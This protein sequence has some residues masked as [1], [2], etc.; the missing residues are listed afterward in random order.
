LQTHIHLQKTTAVQVAVVIMVHQQQTS[1]SFSFTGNNANYG[2]DSISSLQ[3]GNQDDNMSI[4]YLTHV[5]TNVNSRRTKIPPSPK[6]FDHDHSYKMPPPTATKISRLPPSQ[7]TTMGFHQVS[8][9]EGAWKGVMTF[10]R[11]VSHDQS[12]DMDTT[13]SGNH[14]PSSSCST[15]HNDNC[16]FTDHLSSSMTTC[17][18]DEK[19]LPTGS[20]MEQQQHLQRYATV[21]MNDLSALTIRSSSTMDS[22]VVLMNH[23]FSNMGRYTVAHPIQ[24]HGGDEIEE[25][26]DDGTAYYSVAALAA[27]EQRQQY[28]P[29]H[30]SFDLG[31]NKPPQ[32]LFTIDTSTAISSSQSPMRRPRDSHINGNTN[33]VGDI[34]ETTSL[35]PERQ[36]QHCTQDS[37]STINTT[38][39]SK[40]SNNNIIPKHDESYRNLITIAEGLATTRRTAFSLKQPPV[41]QSSLV[42]SSSLF[43]RER[44]NTQSLQSSSPSLQQSSTIQLDSST[45]QETITSTSHLSSQHHFHNKYQENPVYSN[46]SQTANN[47]HQHVF[48]LRGNHFATST[49]AIALPQEPSSLLPGEDGQSASTQSKDETQS[50]GEGG[51][52]MW[53]RQTTSQSSLPPEHASSLVLQGIKTTNSSSDSKGSA[54]LQRSHSYG[55]LSSVQQKFSS[56]RVNSILD[57]KEDVNESSSSTDKDGQADTTSATKSCTKIETRSQPS[58]EPLAS[59]NP[60]A[61]TNKDNYTPLVRKSLLPHA[62]KKTNSQDS[63]PLYQLQRHSTTTTQ[64]RESGQQDAI[65]SPRQENTATGTSGYSMPLP[66]PEASHCSADHIG[67]LNPSLGHF[68]SSSCESLS[69]GDA[70]SKPEPR[71]EEDNTFLSRID[72]LKRTKMSSSEADSPLV[73]AEGGSKNARLK[74][75]GVENSIISVPSLQSPEQPSETEKPKEA[76]L[77][78]PKSDLHLDPKDFDSPNT[79][80]GKNSMHISLEE[81]TVYVARIGELEAK[82][83]MAED[84]IEEQKSWYEQQMAKQHEFTIPFQPYSPF[85]SEKHKKHSPSTQKVRLLERNQTLLKE[86]RFADQTCV[87][88]SQQNA[89][90]KGKLQLREKKLEEM[91]QEQQELTQKYLDSKRMSATAEILSKELEKANKDKRALVERQLHAAYAKLDCQAKRLKVLRDEHAIELKAAFRSGA[92]QNT[93]KID[94]LRFA[95]DLNKQHKQALEGKERDDLSLQVDESSAYKT[96]CRTVFSD[97]DKLNDKVTQLAALATA[98]LDLGSTHQDLERSRLELLAARKER[99]SYSWMTEENKQVLPQLKNKNDLIV[100]KYGHLKEQAAQWRSKAHALQSAGKF[101]PPQQHHSNNVGGDMVQV[102]ETEEKFRQTEFDC[103][104]KVES[105]TIE[106]NMA[107]FSRTEN[108]KSVECQGTPDAAELET[109]KINPSFLSHLLSTKFAN[110]GGLLSPKVI[111]VLQ[112]IHMFT[113]QHWDF[114]DHKIANLTSLY[115]ERLVKLQKLVTHIR[116]SLVFESEFDEESL[117][118]SKVDTDENNRMLDATFAAVTSIPDQKLNLMEEARSEDRMARKFEHSTVPHSPARV[119]ILDL[120][121]IESTNSPICQINSAISIDGGDDAAAPPSRPTVWQIGT[122]KER[123]QV[124]QRNVFR[125][126]SDSGKQ[127]L[128]IL[129]KVLLSLQK[130]FVLHHDRMGTFVETQK[131]AMQQVKDKIYSSSARESR[132]VRERSAVLSD[133]AKAKQS[134]LECYEKIRKYSIDL[135]ASRRSENT[136]SAENEVQRQ[137]ISTLQQDIVDLEYRLIGSSSDIMTSTS[138]RTNSFQERLEASL[139]EQSPSEAHQSQEYKQLRWE[140]DEAIR[141]RQMREIDVRDLKKKLLE[142][143]EAHSTLKELFAESN[144]RLAAAHEVAESH[145]QAIKEL[146]AS[147]QREAHSGQEVEKQAR[148]LIAI[149]R[150]QASIVKDKETLSQR[151]ERANFELPDLQC[152]HHLMKD[153]LSQRLKR[154]EKEYTILEDKYGTAQNTFDDTAKEQVVL[155]DKYKVAQLEMGRVKGEYKKESETKEA[156]KR[157][158]LQQSKSLK[159]NLSNALKEIENSK[160]NIRWEEARQKGNLKEMYGDCNNKLVEAHERVASYDAIG[161]QKNSLESQ[162][163]TAKVHIAGSTDLKQASNLARDFPAEELEHLN[164]EFVEENEEMTTLTKELRDKEN[165]LRDAGQRIQE[166]QDEIAAEL[167]IKESGAEEFECLESEMQ[168]RDASYETLMMNYTTT[169]EKLATALEQL[170]VDAEEKERGAN[171]IIYLK[172]VLHSREDSHATLKMTYTHTNEKLA[173]AFERLNQLEAVAKERECLNAELQTTQEELECNLDEMLTQLNLAHEAIRKVKGGTVALL[174]EKENALKEVRQ[175]SMA[176][177]SENADLTKIKQSC[178]AEID[179]LGEALKTSETALEDVKVSYA[180][181]NDKLSAAQEKASDRDEIADMLRISQEAERPLREKIASIKEEQEILMGKLRDAKKEVED[182]RKAVSSLEQLATEKAAMRESIEAT[183]LQLEE[184]LCQLGSDLQ[185]TQAKLMRSIE[186]IQHLRNELT[187]MTQQKDT[188]ETEI[189]FLCFSRLQLEGNMEKLKDL[190]ASCNDRLAEVQNC[191]ASNQALLEQLEAACEAAESSKEGTEERLLECQN[192]LEKTQKERDQ[193]LREI[194]EANE[195]LVRVDQLREEKEKIA[196]SSTVE[197]SALAADLRSQR[198][199]LEKSLSLLNVNSRS[200]AATHVADV[201]NAMEEIQQLKVDISS[202]CQSVVTLVNK[203]EISGQQTQR[204]RKEVAHFQTIE[205]DLRGSL[206]DEKVASEELTSQ[207][208][209]AR[210]QAEFSSS[211]MNKL[212]TALDEARSREANERRKAIWSEAACQESKL[213]NCENEL[214]TKEQALVELKWQKNSAEKRCLKLREYMRKLTSKCE[215]WETCYAQQNKLLGSLHAQREK[216]KEKALTHKYAEFTGDV[217][218]RAKVSFPFC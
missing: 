55:Q 49:K 23:P 38:T 84:S 118:G 179:R 37:N 19:V 174:T 103:S 107:I 126:P 66:P 212:L 41:K 180:E 95:S 167:S 154:L 165:S 70:T 217:Q 203:V 26:D 132:L 125:E 39:V 198:G 116:S 42:S 4:E 136:M 214:K 211:K 31:Q 210:S 119:A 121:K 36:Y 14:D 186:E 46:D 63:D 173:N 209:H 183:R 196:V 122:K 90:L 33:S 199:E 163:Q 200:A 204:L 164:A 71:E 100:A 51:E 78:P 48:F 91:R 148:Q 156:S 151:L 117:V 218:M 182:G 12:D 61:A 181:C 111:Q 215:E 104:K 138:G 159:D 147:Q 93:R 6:S 1:G 80:P 187:E 145:D 96:S 69:V 146:Q 142:A 131:E 64:T 190:Y 40:S 134:L 124:A 56:W 157:M 29:A 176:V 24:E 34:Y 177:R 47:G 81:S 54:M 30:N 141:S 115:G 105:D 94:D 85:D 201:G 52:F 205:T 21:T 170:R 11:A 44:T 112:L 130:D 139:S 20:G 79:A 53:T 150:S 57:S 133:L 191:N 194:D 152:R 3:S 168:A 178:I 67:S 110:G 127:Q 62:I 135:H 27:V 185:N 213:V 188:C 9:E 114:V 216:T 189:D 106:L 192:E 18:R 184:I 73:H 137:R 28:S 2:T 15:S 171:E 77:T 17:V 60:S 155:Q 68:L 207:L 108:S 76:V 13:V 86:I 32:P 153:A 197:L 128:E 59:G 89:A 50:T 88:L 8:I 175:E 65:F 74:S 172:S 162:L 45:I 7:T 83:K 25:L 43:Q 160:R 75:S 206:Q 129:R 101:Y 35:T 140:L 208:Q 72:V 113:Q 92:N 5:L 144:E 98:N 58:K 97:R 161:S 143:E 16:T 99:K 22:S 123:L 82:L 102:D 202:F 195:H 169:S 10:P 158:F 166:L 109:K 87:E 193:L 120:S 149:Q